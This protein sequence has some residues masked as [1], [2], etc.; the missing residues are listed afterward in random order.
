M[1][2]VACSSG[3]YSLLGATTCTTCPAG[4]Y[5]AVTDQEPVACSDGEYSMAGAT[6]CTECEAGKSCTATGTVNSCPAG[7]ELWVWGFAGNISETEAD[8]AV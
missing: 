4:Y 2:P 5:C 1:A 8:L 6:A 7:M 3:K